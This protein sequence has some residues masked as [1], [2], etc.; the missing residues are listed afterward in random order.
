MSQ[1]LRLSPRDLALLESLALRVRLVGQRQ[2]AEA[3]WTGHL[4]NARRRLRQLVEA[5]MITRQVLPAMPLPDL[6]EPV[7]RWQPGQFIPKSEVI[8]FQLQSRWRFRALRPTVVYFPTEM[9]VTYFGGRQRSQSLV[10]HTT[11]DLGVTAI[12]LRFFNH[13]PDLALTWVGEDILAPSRVRQKLPD[14]A[15]VDQ[16]G[17]PSLLIEF[18]GSYGPARVADFHDDAAARGLPYQIW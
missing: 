18:G 14:A 2:A 15:L 6:N 1:F 9:T 3:L 5:G 16:S 11:H 17:E 13:S 10:T 7:V 8:S 12:W 4:A